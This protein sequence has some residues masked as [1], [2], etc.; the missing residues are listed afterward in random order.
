MHGEICK[1]AFLKEKVKIYSSFI[2]DFVAWFCAKKLLSQNQSHRPV[3]MFLKISK[4]RFFV[5]L[6]VHQTSKIVK[7]NM[8]CTSKQGNQKTTTCLDV[9]VSAGN[10][11]LILHICT[12]FILLFFKAVFTVTFLCPRIYGVL[13]QILFLVLPE[14]PR[15]LEAAKYLWTDAY[16]AFTRLEQFQWWNVHSNSQIWQYQWN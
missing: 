16:A 15:T 3:I 14:I 1:F 7:T 2:L 9:R 5:L 13:A 12:I 8:I 6:Q 11:L 4:N 10:T